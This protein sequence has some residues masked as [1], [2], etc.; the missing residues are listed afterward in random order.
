MKTAGRRTS[1]RWATMPSNRAPC[2]G[3]QNRSCSIQ[4]AEKQE[5]LQPAQKRFFLTSTFIELIGS[6]LYSCIV[7]VPPFVARSRSV[8]INRIRIDYTVYPPDFKPGESPYWDFRTFTKAKFRARVLGVGARVY[9]NFNQTNKR[10]QPLG[11]WW[12][13]KYFWRWT[14]ARFQRCRE[15]GARVGSA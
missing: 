4:W 13:D 7:R 9:R 10:G 2:A 11:D 6:W 1:N 12:G 8:A 14:G 3:G 5:K 15:T